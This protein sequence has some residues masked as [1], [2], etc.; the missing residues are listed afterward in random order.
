MRRLLRPRL[1]FSTLA[2]AVLA[3][4]AG[5]WLYTQS[6][7][8]TRT[9]EQKLEDRLGTVV[10]FESLSVGVT[11]TTISQVRIHERDTGEETEPFVTVRKVDLDL[12]ALAARDN[13]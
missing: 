8:A 3:T 4:I 6:N 12:N 10:R 13:T 9:V 2:I 11:G 7:A 5:T 1:I